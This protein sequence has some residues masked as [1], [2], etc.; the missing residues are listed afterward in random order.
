MTTVRWRQVFST[1]WHEANGP[2]QRQAYVQHGS[3]ILVFTLSAKV[4]E[5]AGYEKTWNEIVRSVRLRA[6]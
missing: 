5:Q 6:A 4:N 3:V 1:V 2:L